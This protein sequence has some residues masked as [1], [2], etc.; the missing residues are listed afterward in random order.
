MSSKQPSTKK[1]QEKQY[2]RFSL[3]QRIEHF[4]LLVTFALLGVTGLVQKYAGADISQAIIDFFGGIEGTRLVHRINAVGLAIV[5]IFHVIDVM[6]RVLVLRHSM[7]MLPTLD[8]FKH[9]IEDVKYYIGLAKERAQYGRYNYGEK[10]E[11]FA[12][13]W[14][15]LLMGA[16][17]FMMWNPIAS[18]KFLPGE[19]I[20]AAKAA[21]SGEALLAVLAI[22]IWHFYNVHI[23]TFNKSMFTGKLTRSEMEHEHPVELA[24]LDKGKGHHPPP[25]HILKKRQQYF[26]P[27][28]FIILTTMSFGL[29]KF[30]T[31]EETAI[32]TVL[33]AETSSVFAP[34]T[35]T[36]KPTPTPLPTPTPMPAGGTWESA[37]AEL[38]A[39]KCSVCHGATALGELSVQSYQDVLTGGMSGPAVVPGDPDG[40]ILVQ[41]QSEG[42]HAGQLTIDELQGIIDWIL[43]GAPEN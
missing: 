32:R 2:T 4:A 36:P 20:P 22:I 40:S 5:S 11:Y 24:D 38:L 31:I 26:F 15:T 17:G 19:Y 41:V 34:I 14:G 6:Y 27:A 9:V 37:Y 8:D 30:V 18:A 16:T 21:H 25:A 3:S 29:F 12:V 43:E 1:V 7:S 39:Q 35:P 33:D 23:K 10:V 13:V 28:A 42:N